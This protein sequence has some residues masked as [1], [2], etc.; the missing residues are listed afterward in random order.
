MAGHTGSWWKFIPIRRLAMFVE[1]S[2]QEGTTWVASE[3]NDV[4]LWQAVQRNVEEFLRM[5]W[6]VGA[7]EGATREEAYFCRCDDQTTTPDL[8]D[9]NMVRFHVGFA[10]VRPEEFMVLEFTQ[11][12]GRTM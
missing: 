4:L 9:L 8:M 12:C 10:P 3:P 2:I 6:K 7:L 11:P 5:L 1:R